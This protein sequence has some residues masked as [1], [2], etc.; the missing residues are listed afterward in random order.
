MRSYGEVG[1]FFFAD[2]FA[3]PGM[4]MGKAD[5]SKRYD[6]VMLGAAGSGEKQVAGLRLSVGW[7]KTVAPSKSQMSLDTSVA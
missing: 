4:R 7:R 6:K 2:D 3:N 5:P 1:K